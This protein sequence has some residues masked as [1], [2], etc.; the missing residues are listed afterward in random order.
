MRRGL[1]A[2][3]ADDE[4]VRTPWCVGHDDTLAVLRR[5]DPRP[6]PPH[7][8]CH[9]TTRRK[10]GCGGAAV[11]RWC[12]DGDRW[13]P[14]IGVQA[15]CA[16]V[17][18]GGHPGGSTQPSLRSCDTWPAG[19]AD[20]TAPQPPF[21]ADM[22]MAVSCRKPTHH[23]TP[24]HLR[25]SQQLGWHNILHCLARTRAE[26]TSMATVNLLSLS[27]KR[28]L[29]VTFRIRLTARWRLHRALLVNGTYR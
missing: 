27:S 14:W 5:T 2:S 19:R 15:G 12:R 3:R 23:P 7:D 4:D 22:A 29:T 10:I 9:V 13:V 8:V 11:T 26:S 6:A 24:R 28:A 21:R 1:E 18:C 25:F 20:S 16:A 17:C